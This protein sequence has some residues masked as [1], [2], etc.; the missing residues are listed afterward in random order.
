MKDKNPLSFL[1]FYRRNLVKLSPFFLISL[2]SVFAIICFVAFFNSWQDT[3]RF[4]NAIWK[5]SAILFYDRGSPDPIPLIAKKSFVQ[6]IY[7]L[8]SEGEIG[9]KFLGGYANV[10]IL[11]IK[12]EYLN[13]LMKYYDITLKTGR[14]P[15][16]NKNEIVAS[17]QIVKNKKWKLNQKVR[18]YEDDE[19]CFQLVGILTGKIGIGF[20]TSKKSPKLDPQKIKKGYLIT[21]NKKK[22]NYRDI[23]KSLENIERNY[24]KRFKCY[25]Y[26][27]YWNEEWE[28]PIKDIQKDINFVTNISLITSIIVFCLISIFLNVGYFQ[29]RLG[30]FGLL[31]SLGLTK[32]QIIKK[33]FW[34]NFLG[35]GISWFLGILISNVFLNILYIFIFIPKGWF[36]NTFPVEALP[37]TLLIPL[38]MLICGFLV[39]IYKI[40]KLDPIEIIE[41]RW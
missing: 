41:R 7:P 5:T 39:V 2:F 29:E 22:L 36:L 9:L 23:A 15:K 28:K 8:Q 3:A 25:L 30:E 14:L 34:E 11:G 26:L 35:I 1:I 31:L 16:E 18:L 17:E 19:I 21:Y 37:K 38:G 12:P 40:K 24:E 27:E 4:Y 32:Y 13:P 20:Y 10:R 33:S 6:D